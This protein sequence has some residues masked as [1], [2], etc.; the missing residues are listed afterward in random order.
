M[1]TKTTLVMLWLALSPVAGFYAWGKGRSGFRIF[2]L[3]LLSP[4]IGMVV[5]LY[6]QPRRGEVNPAGKVLWQISLI[7]GL[8]E[9]LLE[10]CS[11]SSIDHEI[12]P[13]QPLLTG[14]LV[15]GSMAT[16]FA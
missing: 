3:S 12:D 6:I 4:L 2:L 1:P 8:Y 14:L 16:F 9:G 15:L 5:A 7:C 11:Q 13:W 10:R